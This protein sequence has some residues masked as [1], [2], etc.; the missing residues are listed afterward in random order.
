MQI[1]DGLEG[2]RKLP[3]GLALSVGNFDGLHRGHRQ[4]IELAKSLNGPAGVAVVT[5]EPHPFTVLRP[6]HAPPRL[7]PLPLKIELLK[8][9]GVDHLAILPPTTSL[10]NLT[11]EAFWQI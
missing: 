3:H 11:A 5:F 8:E 6:G 2:L 4:I 1:H 10:L 7:T 9:I